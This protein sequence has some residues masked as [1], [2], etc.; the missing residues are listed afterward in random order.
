MRDIVE[1]IKLA[2]KWLVGFLSILPK[3]SVSLLKNEEIRYLLKKKEFRHAYNYAYFLILWGIKD[4]FIIR[5]L[6]RLAPY[7]PCIEVEVTT[8]CNLK[9]I[10]CE[11][12]YWNEENRDMSF[13]EFKM[14]IDQFP[15][16]KWIGLAGIGESFLN[17]DFLKMLEYVKSKHAYVELYDTFYF[18]DEIISRKIIEMGVKMTLFASIDA[19]TKET[20]EKIRIGSNFERVINNVKNFI[21][22]KEKK[23]AYFPK[24]VF[25]FVVSK[26]NLKEIPQYLEM[27]HSISAGENVSIQ[28]TRLLHNFDEVKDIFTE[29]PE[30]VV[31]EA[32]RK[33]RELGIRISWNK[34]VPR[35]KPPISQC[36]AWIMPFIFV[37]G[38][39]VPCCASNE[40]NRREFQKK[41]SMGNMFA[42]PF[43]EIWY[44]EK[45]RNFRRTIL[46]C[47]VPKQCR[48]C[49][50]FDIGD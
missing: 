10:M 14:I 7:P 24:L 26:L 46:K 32:E 49:S 38:H 4:P 15:N 33:S 19:A 23:N 47:G 18:I 29:I 5:L 35:V 22:L 34:D 44:S 28:F 43:R 1:N 27:I 50:I 40:A 17:K 8:R 42:A 48:N 12:T 11:H 31:L 2:Q 16:L 21:Q 20:Y 30:E 9:C 6:H 3:S 41:H 37:T 13:E 39:V 36:V 45:Y 25:H